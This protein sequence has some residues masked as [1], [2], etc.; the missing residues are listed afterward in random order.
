MPPTFEPPLCLSE[1]HSPDGD[2]C[3]AHRHGED[4]PE[5]IAHLAASG[6]KWMPLNQFHR[7]WE[8]VD[9]AARCRQVQG[10]PYADSDADFAE[11]R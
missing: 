11:S 2:H 6:V 3:Y 7:K 10:N 9:V 8:L 4:P 5:H 1:S